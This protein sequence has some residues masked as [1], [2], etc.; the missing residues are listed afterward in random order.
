MKKCPN[1]KK[2]YAEY[3]KYCV[4]CSID[5]ETQK[6][7]PQ[8]GIFK[9]VFSN[10]IVD[11]IFNGKKECPNC[12]NDITKDVQGKREIRCSR[13]SVVL[14]KKEKGSGCSK[15]VSWKTKGIPLE[16]RI[17]LAIVAI[18]V[19]ICIISFIVIF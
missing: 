18:L 1:C 4:D 12:R 11:N 2:E 9:Q 8:V 15:V 19:L 16:N 6:E 17:A 10:E 13:C 3:E 14:I 7:A 5:L